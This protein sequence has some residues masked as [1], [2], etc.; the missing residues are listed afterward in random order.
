M[1]KADGAAQKVVVIGA[2]IVGLACAS[3]L[4]RDGHAVTLVDRLPPGEG[5]SFGNAGGLS[6]GSVVPLA[7][8][9]TAAKV[10]GWLLDPLGPLALRWSY[11]PQALPW[12]IRFARAGKPAQVEAIADAL[13]ALHGQVFENYDPLVEAAGCR[14]LIVRKGQLYVYQSEAAFQGDAE[15]WRLRRERGVAVEVIA[16]E[17][18]RQLE[19]NLAP[20]FARAVLLPEHG[21]CRNPHRLVTA[22][23]EAFKRD[24][25]EILRREVTGFEIGAQGPRA[26]RSPEGDIET[27]KVVIA[28]GA[29]SHKLARGLGDRIPLETQRGYHVTLADPAAQPERTVMWAER[30]FMTSPMEP[31]LR[32]AGTAEFAGLEAAPDWR[33]AEVLV[34][35]VKQL[36]PGLAGGPDFGSD[37]VSTWMGHRPCLPDT[38]P[39]IGRATQAANTVFAFGHGHTGLTGASTTGR[40][41][42]DLIAGR[43]PPL[44][45][46]PFRADRF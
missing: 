28:A 1:A 21:Q 27:D 13:R 25:G 36:L 8:P 33:R 16:A 18:I 24:G 2:G 17:E 7:L 23:A 42:A 3:Y 31:G 34:G 32:V 45:L 40:L 43:T 46:A 4:R 29:W 15:G 6:P 30:K 26:L 20:I 38:L 9:G 22:L 39:V 35:Q 19:P 44:D 5:C 14:D 11:L 12:L 37:K 10:P 41:V